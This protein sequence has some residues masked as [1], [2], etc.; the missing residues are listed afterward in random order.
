[1]RTHS[2]DMPHSHRDAFKEEVRKEYQETKLQ[3]IARKLY[4][5]WTALQNALITLW[6][7]LKACFSC[8]GRTFDPEGDPDVQ[9]LKDL[10][11]RLVA[12][13]EKV[14]GRPMSNLSNLASRAWNSSVC[15]GLDPCAFCV[16]N[17]LECLYSKE[18]RRRGPPSGYL[19]Y[20]ETRVAILEILLG[21]YLSKLPKKEEG[22]DQAAD[23]FLEFAQT[24]QSEAKTCTQDVWD[25]HKA[26]WTKC[27]SAK[28]VEELTISFAPFTPRSAQEAPVKTLLPLSS[29][30]ASSSNDRHHPASTPSPMQG[31]EGGRR[32]NEK[33]KPLNQIPFTQTLKPESFDAT[34]SNDQSRSTAS[35]LSARTQEDVAQMPGAAPMEEREEQW[36]NSG[37]YVNLQNPGSSLVYP[38]Q[39][40]R[41]DAV[42]LHSTSSMRLDG[43]PDPLGVALGLDDQG[44]TGSYWRT[45][46]L[47]NP[48]SESFGPIPVAQPNLLPLAPTNQI[49]VPPSHILSRLLDVYYQHAHPSYP[50]LPSRS[51]LDATLSSP[52]GKSEIW[53]TLVLSICAYS[54]RLS[55]S[56]NPAASNLL[57]GGTGGLAGKIAAD[58]WYEQAR[59]SLSTLLKKGSSIE[60]VR[61][62]LLLALRDYGKGNESQAW[63]LVGLAVRMAQDLQ[64]HEESNDRALQL[65]AEENQLRRNVWGVCVI[66]DLLLSLQM[67]RPPAT[68][69]ALKGTLSVQ[70]RP[71]PPDID[72]NPSPPFTYAVSLCRVIS[73]INF[74]LYLGY[75]SSTA[76]SPPDKLSHLRTELDMWHHSLP[77]QYRISIGHQPRRDVLE[78]NMLYHVAIILLYRPISRDES[79]QQ[80]T[81]IFLEAAS[82]FNVLLEKYRQSQATPSMSLT[83]P[84]T[85]A[86]NSPALSHT[87]PNMIYLIYT[88]AI[89]HLSGYKIRQTQQQQL[90]SGG[91]FNQVAPAV[92]VSPTS[93]LQTQLHL[94][95]CSEA[96]ASIGF[97]WELARRCW[98]ALD[99]FM[100]MENLKPRSGTGAGSVAGIGGSPILELQGD[101][102]SLTLGK[103]KREL[104]DHQKRTPWPGPMGGKINSPVAPGTPVS[105]TKQSQQ[106]QQRH[107]TSPTFPMDLSPAISDLGVLMTPSPSLPTQFAPP[108]N[109]TQLAQ[110]SQ[111]N[112]TT[113]MG[114][115][116]G[117]GDGSTSV[118]FASG[119]ET[120]LTAFDPS[121]F[122][123][124]WM[125]DASQA[126][127]A[128]WNNSWDDNAWSQ[129]YVNSGMSMF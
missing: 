78:I 125:Q 22:D 91:G 82:S 32:T 64:L 83:S 3:L 77:M 24:L 44:Y 21:L 39:S 58:L 40:F 102:D 62:S 49:D 8:H 99:T 65:T 2:P 25:A 103:R 107:P 14:T 75:P 47:A 100:E 17:K 97:T 96:L 109:F 74:H 98:K 128:E 106:Q 92:S 46:D 7:V 23:P 56:T 110:Q 33:S 51:S 111:N 122:S 80:A 123:A 112:L 35:P 105:P 29:A 104:E 11:Q 27:P 85:A 13:V 26:I 71:R 129:S 113:G 5:L 117:W 53:S 31:K 19:R 41:R 50:L 57:A 38:P 15:D 30:P 101:K 70:S 12:K 89:A 119:G 9:E 59:T 69:D 55:L 95:K 20:T 73:L 90:A 48:E 66:L 1:M 60:L 115:A 67:G 28:L 72:I 114:G 36:Q 127:N 84:S 120:G 87:N 116:S 124:K 68:S 88:V 126:W 37:A 43:T 42:Q 86:N 34:G 16:D 79:S 76:Q 108:Q 121:L 54:G 94:L 45:V 118:S 63:V 4:D 93:A 10:S 52:C 81:D 61:A 18:P 6:A